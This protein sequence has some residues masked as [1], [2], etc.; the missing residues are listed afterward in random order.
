MYL[1]ACA[2]RQLPAFAALT[3][4]GAPDLPQL[5]LSIAFALACSLVMAGIV[6]M[7]TAHF[8][9][10]KAVR[11]LP[12]AFLALLLLSPQILNAVVGQGN[13]FSALL[14]G[15]STM[16]DAYLAAGITAVGACAFY[17]AA[18]AVAIKLYAR[19]DL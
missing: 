8:G 11:F 14:K 9:L 7:L 16:P 5:A 15:A 19:R 4:A 3:G 18:S 6:L 13:T 17:L 10:T 12:G 2:V 1:G